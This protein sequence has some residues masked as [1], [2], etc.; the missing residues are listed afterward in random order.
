MSNK[1]EINIVLLQF[2]NLIMPKLALS[3]GI[4]KEKEKKR[5]N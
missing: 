4:K 2:L 3:K 1:K 5:R